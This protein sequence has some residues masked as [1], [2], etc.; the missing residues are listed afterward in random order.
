[1]F[2]VTGLNLIPP[3]PAAMS[4]AELPCRILTAA[5]EGE[6]LF[7]RGIGN[8]MPSLRFGR[9]LERTGTGEGKHADCAIAGGRHVE[10]LEAGPIGAMA[11]LKLPEREPALACVNDPEPAEVRDSR[12]KASISTT[13]L[14]PAL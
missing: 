9:N 10:I 3:A 5:R 12:N 1:M 13:M 4:A 8:R 6:K 14:L 11:L 7:P 2:T